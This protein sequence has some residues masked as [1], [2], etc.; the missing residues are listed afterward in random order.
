MHGISIQALSLLVLAGGEITDDRKKDKA[1]S[2]SAEEMPEEPRVNVA[3]MGGDF[4]MS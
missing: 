2:N 3:N 1:T 4:L